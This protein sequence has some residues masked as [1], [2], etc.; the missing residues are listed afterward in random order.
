MDKIQIVNVAL[1]RIGV[2]AIESL[3]EASE[4]ARVATRYYDLTRQLVLRKYPWGFATRR[5]QL[6]QLETKPNDYKYAYRYPADVLYLRGIY[7]EYYDKPVHDHH[8]K[9]LSDKSGKVLY[10]D[11][12]HASI[13]Y[14]AD[15]ED[16]TL[17]DAQFVEAFA[18]KLAA[19]I[20]FVL[21]GNIGIAQ[22]AVQA[23]NAYVNEA[24]GNDAE[25]DNEPQDPI[26][27]R[28]ADA[29]WTGC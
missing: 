20:A 6:A 9:I 17:F 5:T 1:G 2:A 14:T 8:Y 21:T 12:P 25:E 26:T 4:A 23:Y 22:N 28:L 16:A 13:E 18:W 10:S 7:N 3:S 27:N 11:V 19:E 24:M 15:I 29:R